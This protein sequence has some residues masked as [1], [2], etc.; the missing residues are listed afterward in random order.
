MASILWQITQ[1]P[2]WQPPV[3]IYGL[4]NGW[5]VKMDLAGI[6]SQDLDISIKGKKLIVR[7]QRRDK[8]VPRKCK[9]YHMEIAYNRFEREIELPNVDQGNSIHL[10]YQL[11][12]L[13]ITIG[14]S[15]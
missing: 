11:G 8:Q 3:D 4:E 6:S 2:F 12:M 10:D 14:R 9:P 7:G 5:L 15:S 1:G 13:L